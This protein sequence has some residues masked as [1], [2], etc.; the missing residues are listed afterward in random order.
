[1]RL[2]LIEKKEAKKYPTVKQGVTEQ[3]EGR[4]SKEPGTIQAT[5]TESAPQEDIPVAT[6]SKVPPIIRML[7]YPRFLVALFATCTQGILMTGLETTL[8]LHVLELFE[9]SASKSGL[10]FLALVVP[11]LVSPLAGMIIDKT[12]PRWV[13]VSGFILCTP[14][15]ILLRLPH[16]NTSRDIAI[17]IVML[18]FIG[19]GLSLTTL[20]A[21]ITYFLE[22]LEEK[23]PGSF[24]PRGAYA[25]GVRFSFFS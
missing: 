11:T 20:L 7:R 25:Q 17:M 12:G 18:A 1:M 6:G 2:V 16:E 3:D 19:F 9:F 4:E 22:S 14:F 5:N 21:E 13:A 23:E 15:Y 24:G 8:P 10:L